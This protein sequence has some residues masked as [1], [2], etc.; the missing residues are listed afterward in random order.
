LLQYFLNDRE[1]G[2]QFA[3]GFDRRILHL[4]DSLQRRRG[5]GRE[6]RVQGNCDAHH[7]CCANRQKPNASFERHACTLNDGAH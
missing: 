2:S 1:L 7:Y 6:M 4:L 3:H 5:T